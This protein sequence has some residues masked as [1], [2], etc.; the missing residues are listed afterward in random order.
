MKARPNMSNN[1]RLGMIYKTFCNTNP[2][3]NKNKS[4]NYNNNNLPLLLYH[5]YHWWM[6]IWI[7]G[8]WIDWRTWPR[9]ARI[10]TRMKWY[11]TPYKRMSINSNKACENNNNNNNKHCNS[12][13][14]YQNR[15]KPWRNGKCIVR[16]RHGWIK[17]RTPITTS[18]TTRVKIPPATTIVTTTIRQSRWRMIVIIGYCN[19]WPYGRNIW[20]RKRGI[21]KNRDWRAAPSYPL[22]GK[23]RHWIPPAPAPAPHQRRRQ[24]LRVTTRPVASNVGN[25]WIE[26]PC[27]PWKVCCWK[28]IRPGVRNCKKKLI[29]SRPRWKRTITWMWTNLRLTTTTTTT[30]FDS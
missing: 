19:N 30:T 16:L 4:R 3:N 7:N 15:H 12:P 10:P 25:N 8:R 2:W 23:N 13:P 14:L 21:G 5:N 11:W 27:K 22:P 26:C 1:P 29:I 24:Q 28:R 17:R 6:K 9:H 20:K 18:T